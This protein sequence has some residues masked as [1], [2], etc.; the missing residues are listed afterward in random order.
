MCVSGDAP[1]KSDP[2]QGVI[3]DS[4]NRALHKALSNTPTFLSALFCFFPMH[5]F[6]FHVCPAAF[7]TR[8]FLCLFFCFTLSNLHNFP[9]LSLMCGFTPLLPSSPAGLVWFYLH[10]FLML[11]SLVSSLF[12]PVHALTSVFTSISLFFIFFYCSVTSFSLY[13]SLCKVM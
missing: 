11:S 1:S 2:R 3:N 5:P 4:M 12:Y 9:F 7:L 10:L 6:S 13:F 8:C